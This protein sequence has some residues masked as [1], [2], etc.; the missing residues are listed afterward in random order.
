MK[1]S[2]L[3]I[4]VLRSH[5]YG[6]ANLY[7]DF[8]DGARTDIAGVKFTNENEP[9]WVGIGMGTTYNWNEDKYS[10]FGEASV[11]TSVNHFGD[12]YTARGNL[13]FR[14]KF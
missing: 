7:Y 10:L 5:V 12:S 13:G 1:C 8:L 14:V 9:L 2:Y 6:I 11:N 4:K 3:R